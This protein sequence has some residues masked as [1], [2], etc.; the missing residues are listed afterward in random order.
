MDVDRLRLLFEPQLNL[1]LRRHRS[2]FE[3]EVEFIGDIAKVG[4][5]IPVQPTD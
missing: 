5:V 3:P 1:T 4:R 2:T